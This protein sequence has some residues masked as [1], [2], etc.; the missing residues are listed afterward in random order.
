MVR[1][2]F[3]LAALMLMAVQMTT[4]QEQDRTFP[5]APE[6]EILWDEW[7]VPHIVAPDNAS[8][9]YAFGWAQAHNHG[10]LILRLYGEAR[11]RAA[12][13]WGADHLE[14]DRLI[15]TLGIPQ[16][17][18]QGYA[19]LSD[20]WRD[21][22]DAFAAGITDYVT[23]NADN[24]GDEFEVVLPV[25]GAD[26]VAH[27]TRVLRWSFVAG[28]GVGYARGQD[29]G[30]PSGSNAWAIGP[31]R[32]ASG[33]AMLVANP[34]QPWVD[35]G[36]WVEAHFMTPDLNLYGAA[37]LGQPV[38]GIAF[39]DHLGWAHTVNTHDGWDLYE[40][41]LTDDGEGYIFDGEAMP[42]EIVEEAIQIA[43]DDGGMDEE[44]LIRR[45][46]VHGPVLAFHEP[47][48]ALA[49]RVVGEDSFA[50]AEQWWEM[51]NATNLTEF[52]AAI[53][54]VRIPMFT[55][56]YADRDGNILNVFNEQ[57]P[58]RAEGDWEFW[59]GT[60]ILD[61]TPSVIPGDTS[62]YLW[63]R[64]YHPYED[65]PR[66]LNPETGWLQNA[67]E[68]PY[69]M[70]LPPPFLPGDFP[71]YML[72]DPYVWPR[73]IQSM[74]LLVEDESITF[75]ELLD[76]KHST[77]VELTNAVLDDLIAAARDSGDETAIQAADVLEA[78]DR[79]TDADSQ[80]AVLFIVWAN[81]HITGFEAIAS[82]WDI[83]EPL[84]SLRGLTDPESAVADLIEVAEGLEQLRVL[85]IGM[86]VPYGEV[87]RLRY[88]G[89]DVDLPANGTE[90]LL[91]SFRILTFTQDDDQRFRP[92]H[93]DSYIAVVEFSDPI[94]AEVLLSYGNATQ[95]GSPHV[96]DQLE[97]FAEQDLR[98]A[99]LTREQIEGAL[100]RVE[101]F[102]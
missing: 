33:N 70:T 9:F 60:D 17:G 69:T 7:G 58:I 22:A 53:S 86:D 82:P 89:S 5:V 74:R 31:S 93:G 23:Q 48:K 56:M 67:N 42:F 92:V 79:R 18:T 14:S 62:D 29:Q 20:E 80:G 28:S 3:V 77:Y 87:F 65:L 40:L 45:S 52:E 10:D 44:T 54:N 61:S 102:D 37:L 32:S 1:I 81:Q 91:G 8:L 66:L 100:V 16:E 94:R 50:A 64:V 6:T 75:D 55:I 34:H 15:R 46:S 83:N 25:T 96:G 76:Y 78:W 84:T 30:S 95:P 21:Y 19:S 49:I 72:P 11:G 73:P 101:T 4:A 63:E 41:T 39:N 47:G 99:L 59:N 36:L 2:S 35:F 57:V 43:A 88:P 98:P 68:P 51:A 12:E 26:I 71:A 27:G 97:L 90:D 24:I 13:Y 85:G 38:L